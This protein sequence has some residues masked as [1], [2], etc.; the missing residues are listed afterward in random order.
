MVQTLYSGVEDASFLIDFRRNISAGGQPAIETL[1]QL[2]LLG[3]VS[4]QDV[5]QSSAVLGTIVTGQTTEAVE[6]VFNSLVNPQAV[7][8]VAAAIKVS[9]IQQSIG[10]TCSPGLYVHNLAAIA[11]GTV[12]GETDDLEAAASS[13]LG[14]F[15]SKQPCAFTEPHLTLGSHHIVELLTNK[16]IDAQH[17]ETILKGLYGMANSRHA[18]LIDGAIP[19]FNH[20]DPSV[21]VAAIRAIA[22]VPTVRQLRH[23]VMTRDTNAVRIAQL[24]ILFIIF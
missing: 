23:Y 10:M 18:N 19:F 22:N 3:E 15:A 9:A 14:A 21:R 5:E 24:V 7:E 4:F 20:S 2:I 1:C 11:N 13:A 17:N 16:T 12:T 8:P 6:A